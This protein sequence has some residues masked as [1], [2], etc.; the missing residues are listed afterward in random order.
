MAKK[1]SLA[2]MTWKEVEEIAK[3]GTV[4]LVPVAAVEQHGHQTPTGIDLFVA[5]H[6]YRRAQR[7]STAELS[8]RRPHRY[9]LTTESSNQ[10]VRSGIETDSGVAS[11]RPIHSLS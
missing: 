10:P 1:T 5:E 3:P 4:V 6:W 9:G 2:R 8:G 7:W 11:G